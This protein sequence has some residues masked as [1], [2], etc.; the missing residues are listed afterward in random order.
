MTRSAIVLSKTSTYLHM[1]EEGERGGDKKE[2][3]G[4]VVITLSV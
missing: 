2:R 4:G 3:E 1:C